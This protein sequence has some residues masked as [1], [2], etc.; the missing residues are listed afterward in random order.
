MAVYQLFNMPPSDAP[1][2]PPRRQSESV[3]AVLIGLLVAC[4][5]VAGG[6]TA[7][8][9]FA[10]KAVPNL[11][12]SQN[13]YSTVMMSLGQSLT[14][15][16]MLVTLTSA[17]VIPT[18]AT[19]ERGNPTA[20][21]SAWLVTFTLRFQNQTAQTQDVTTS[22]WTLSA[23]GG[24][25]SNVNANGAPLSSVA[26]HTTAVESYTARFGYG[27]A[28]PYEVHTD[29]TDANGDVIGWLFNG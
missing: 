12:P 3:R 5:V 20:E 21:P 22:A 24:A 15:D 6:I 27:G 10:T 1:A 29:A 25:Q 7:F 4:V 8:N 19:A 9:L 11:A 14:A 18:V 23:F 17:Q 2:P 28:G 26:P 13:S 16:N